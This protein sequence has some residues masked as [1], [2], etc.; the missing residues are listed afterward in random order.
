MLAFSPAQP[1]QPNSGNVSKRKLRSSFGLF[2]V[3]TID[4]LQDDDIPHD[5][6]DG[7]GDITPLRK[8]LNARCAAA[9]IPIE[10][11]DLLDEQLVSISLP[12]GR[13]RR[14]IYLGNFDS[15]QRL[16][17]LPFEQ[18]V[19]LQG[20]DA[21][22]NYE[23]GI[24]EAAV[25]PLGGVFPRFLYS[26]LFQTPSDQSPKNSDAPR[27]EL[28]SPEF[29]ASMTL[30]PPSTVL[31]TLIPP[32]TRLS[33]T[34]NAGD[35]TQHDK[36][37]DMLRRASDALFFQ[38][39]LVHD[40]PLGL[41]RERRPPSPRPR[42]RARGPSPE[43][44][45]PRYEYD[46]APVSLY[47]YARSAIGM[48]LLQFLAYYQVV[49]YYFPTYSQA[50][51]RRRIRSVLKDPAFRGDKDADLGRLLSAIH[52]SRSGAF[53]DERAQLRS[54]LI[55]CVDADALRQF[56]AA[57][58]PRSDFL[59]SKTKG[60]CDHKIPVASS[61]ADLRNDV[62]ERIYEIRC[63]IVHTKTD[64][65]NSELELLLPFSREAEQ[66]THDIDL[67][68]FVAQQVLIAASSPFRG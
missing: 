48:P 58:A 4:P 6:A 57:D 36:A 56:I 17:S 24:I 44:T 66:L 62:A 10:E 49:E 27:L 51:A 23:T 61:T 18:Y 38:I 21:V 9:E 25:R 64:A 29:N 50:D 15:Y 8:Q 19:F 22:C 30:G 42:R 1:R 32:L 59:S 41:T 43:L 20:L 12:C 40:V 26:A 16:L 28:T 3:A 34:V 5:N 65:K 46:T 31:T 53:G 13:E 63:K 11:E 60:L 35:I 33:L 2:H 39:D 67:V 37:I 14:R 55:E 54:T 68:R 45:F 47:W 52:V 7:H